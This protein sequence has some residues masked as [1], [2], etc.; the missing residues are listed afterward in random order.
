MMDDLTNQIIEQALNPDQNVQPAVEQ[1]QEAP[2]KAPE[3]QKEYNLRIL[4]ERAERAEKRLA[5]LESS[6]QSQPRSPSQPSY[7]QAPEEQVDEPSIDDESYIEGKQLKKVL[8][9]VKR[10][11]QDTRRL[12][13]EQNRQAYTAATEARLRMTFPDF[14]QVVNADNL[15]NL[16]MIHPEDYSSMMANGDLYAKA[17]TAYNM[18]K[19]YKI[20]DEYAEETSRLEANKQKPRSAASLNAQVSRDETPLARVGDYDRRILTEEDRE[21]IRQRV[22]QYK[23]VYRQ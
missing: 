6:Y 7:Q 22:N 1:P 13:E 3:T 10:E 17:K 23:N 19:N 12:M 2:K 15:K 18:I 14:D 8:K 9:S 16:Q 11:L 21:R 20:V 4:R 5:E